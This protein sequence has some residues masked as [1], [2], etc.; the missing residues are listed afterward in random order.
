MVYVMYR[1]G[2]YW[3]QDS[4]RHMNDEERRSSS[5]TKPN[6]YQTQW[7]GQFYVAAELSRRGYIVTFTL[8]N[9]PVTDLLARTYGGCSFAVEV[10]TAATKSMYQVKKP[11][12]PDNPEDLFWVFVSLVEAQPKYFI[13]RSDEV[14]RLWH[15]WNDKFGP[16]TSW[17][18]I[19]QSQV[20]PYEGRWDVLPST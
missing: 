15:E 3:A 12:V 10:K 6:Q 2:T 7:A 5:V 17:P 16:D 4:C 11:P 9:A 8:G 14:L 18:G 13:I 20:K 19:D 1:N